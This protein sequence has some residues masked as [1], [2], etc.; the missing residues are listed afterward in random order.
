MPSRDKIVAAAGKAHDHG[1]LW[2]LEKGGRSSYLYGTIHLA[3]WDLMFPGPTVKR[4]AMASD[5][6]ALELDMLDPDITGRLRAAMA[7]GSDAVL[8]ESLTERLYK[9]A[10]RACLQ[11]QILDR[12][13]P[14][15]RTASL[16]VLAARGEGLY[17][18]YGIDAFLAG[19]ARGIKKPVTSLE[20]PESQLEI[21]HA[22]SPQERDALMGSELDLLEDPQ[23]AAALLKRLVDVWADSRLEELQD[24][25]QW[26]ACA[27]TEDERRE[28]RRM[29]DD[30][31]PGLAERIAAIHD[32]GEQVFAAVGSLHMIGPVALPTLLA[33]KGFQVEFV[34]FAH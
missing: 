2:R 6:F 21:L 12:M 26:C 20:R 19:F 4:A 7:I 22:E 15:M 32:G 9:A 34:A 27:E 18:D 8:P 3:T 29:L 1:F 5:R 16:M 31:N 24:Y 23:T 28:L 30:R 17:P 13:F 10:D 33:A 11:H 14:E 25:A